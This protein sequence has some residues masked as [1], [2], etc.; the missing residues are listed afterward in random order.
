MCFQ[1]PPGAE[2]LNHTPLPHVNSLSSKLIDGKRQPLDRSGWNE[3]G[4][5]FFLFAM[6]AMIG[7]YIADEMTKMRKCRKSKWLAYSL[8]T[9]A[10]LLVT[11][12]FGLLM[13]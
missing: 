6:L 4:F 9:T 7:W 5:T 3:L 10:F 2:P 11:I 13:K 1:G 8:W 12:G